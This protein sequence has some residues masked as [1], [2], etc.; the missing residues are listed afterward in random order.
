M[1]KNM[2][3]YSKENSAAKKVSTWK[4]DE[5]IKDHGNSTILIDREGPGFH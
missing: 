3:I 2:K 4:E 5:N 1:N